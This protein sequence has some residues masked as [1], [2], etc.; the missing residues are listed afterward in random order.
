MADVF[1]TQRGIDPDTGGDLRT[2]MPV[3]GVGGFKMNLL[4]Y[5]ISV[6]DRYWSTALFP[7]KFFL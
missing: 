1:G 2:A 7:P 5:I 3:R 4:G 6:L